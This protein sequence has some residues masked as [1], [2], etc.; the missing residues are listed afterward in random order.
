VTAVAMAALEGLTPRRKVLRTFKTGDKRS[1][2][3]R[4]DLKNWRLSRLVDVCP[5]IAG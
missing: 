4:T 1:R 2:R 3:P 5:Q